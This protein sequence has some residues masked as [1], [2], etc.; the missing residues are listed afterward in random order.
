MELGGVEAAAA[1]DAPARAVS[2]ARRRGRRYVVVAAALCTACVVL[3][4]LALVQSRTGVRAVAALQEMLCCD[5]CCAA[6]ATPSV[7]SAIL[8]RDKTR[9]GRSTILHMSGTS[10]IDYTAGGHR[11]SQHMESALSELDHLENHVKDGRPKFLMESAAQREADL[12]NG[13]FAHQ[14]L[15]GNQDTHKSAR[16]HKAA[17]TSK[18]LEDPYAQDEERQLAEASRRSKMQAATAKE[19]EKRQLA[20]LVR[21]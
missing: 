6:S 4:C 2:T 11:V 12:A 5:G 19:R 10:E 17:V 3:A 1:H 7:T 21:M 18:G 9:S 16:S 15:E 14:D 13:K 20:A 8:A